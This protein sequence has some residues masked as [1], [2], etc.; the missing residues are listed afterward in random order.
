MPHDFCDL[1]TSSLFHFR[2]LRGILSST[3]A[4]SDVQLWTFWDGI[5]LKHAQ[6][7][8]RGVS[9]TC[10]TLI[11][12]RVSL[13]CLVC[14]TNLLCI[15]LPFHHSISSPIYNHYMLDQ[16]TVPYVCVKLCVYGTKSKSCFHCYHTP[17]EICMYFYWATLSEWEGSGKK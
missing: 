14:L 7:L 15:H 12:L 5:H 17:A 3:V 10:D 6:W 13:L 8:E 16:L 11:L 2:S 9:L 1:L 4:I